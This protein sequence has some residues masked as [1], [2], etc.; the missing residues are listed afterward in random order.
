M[1]HTELLKEIE[2]RNF[3]PV[4]F[5]H[6]E[7]SYFIDV[8]ADALENNILNEAE[9]AFNQSVFYGKDTDHQTLLDTARRFPM[10]APCQVVFLKEAQDMKSLKELEGYVLK[11]VPTTVLVICYKN[12]KLNMNTTLGKALKQNARVFE[13][14][15]LYD[16]QVP[17]WIQSYLQDRKFKIKGEAAALMAEYLGTELSKVA[18]E[19]DKLAINLSPGTEITSKDIESQI[20]IS[21]DFNIFEL[22]KAIGQR[23]LLKV[24]RIVQ[25]FAA[26]ARRNPDVVTI[27]SLYNF[28]SK[29]YILQFYKN[30]SEKEQAEALDLKSAYF[31]KDYRA[32]LTYFNKP[33][34]E[35]AIQ[36]LREYDL[37]SKGVGY[38]ATG[39]AEG[40]LLRELTWKLMHLDE[41][42]QMQS[43][44]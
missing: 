25:Y 8:L 32:A 42:I 18:N 10:M 28:F 15:R 3:H 38:N 40:T 26:N 41:V 11:P 22:Q 9:R 21:K 29:L 33:R 13:S 27:G 12:G 20:G 23:Q 34:T 1:P 44:G 4:Y 43:N 19:L 7:E 24:N 6:G 14:K 36:L 37:K 2:Q 17:D 5:M 31:L 35:A 16:N 39:K 30:A